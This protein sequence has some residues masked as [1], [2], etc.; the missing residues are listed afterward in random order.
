VAEETKPDEQQ[1]WAKLSDFSKAVV[2]D[3][4]VNLL[5][6]ALTYITLGLIGLVVIFALVQRPDLYAAVVCSAPLLDMVRYEQFGLG[7][8]WS[9]E[10]GSAAVA[11]LVVGAASSRDPHKPRVQRPRGKVSAP[12]TR[13]R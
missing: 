9:D 1:S 2:R 13:G 11:V 6:H 12:R 7:A 8:T 10:F 4:V 5:A 3:A